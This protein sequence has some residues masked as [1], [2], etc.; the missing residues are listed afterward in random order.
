MNVQGRVELEGIVNKLPERQSQCNL[1]STEMSLTS[2]SEGGKEVK[3]L[4]TLLEEDINE[5]KARIA[6]YE[7]KM[8]A[9]ER[10]RPVDEEW[11]K[12]QWSKYL[13]WQDEVK[14]L[15]ERLLGLESA[16]RELS[17]ASATGPKGK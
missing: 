9:F 1:E 6:K 17:F 15:D 14:V 5:V 12:E 16:R 13:K 3:D 10:R 11:L 8:E 7:G 4:V 2:K